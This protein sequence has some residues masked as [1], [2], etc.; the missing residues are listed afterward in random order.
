MVTTQL[1]LYIFASLIGAGLI[2]LYIY[3]GVF[4]GTKDTNNEIYKHLLIVG[5]ITAVL[6]FIY[7]WMM[8]LY[9]QSNLNEATPYLL[10]SNTIILFLSLYSLTAS[11][12]QVIAN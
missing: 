8:Y 1:L 12:I 9:F 11:S 2:G 5:S 10:I 6:V 3:I 4:L 7:G